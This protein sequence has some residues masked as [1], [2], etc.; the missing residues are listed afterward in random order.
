MSDSYLLAHLHALG[1]EPYN[2]LAARPGADYQIVML[3]GCY[4]KVMV[5]GLLLPEA[6]GALTDIAKRLE[7][8]HD[9]EF[10]IEFELVIEQMD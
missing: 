8:A 7:P 6:Q 5:S 3:I 2:N 9:S 4:R 1:I 10:V